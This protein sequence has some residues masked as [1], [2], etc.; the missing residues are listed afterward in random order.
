M[1]LLLQQFQHPLKRYEQLKGRVK[2][3]LA[4]PASNSGVV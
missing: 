2:T 4:V 1:F 3:K